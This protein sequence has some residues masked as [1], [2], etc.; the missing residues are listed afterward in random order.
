MQRH[1][2]ILQFWRCVE[3]SWTALLCLTGLMTVVLY[4]LSYV[5]IYTEGE[6][7]QGLF[8][9]LVWVVGG[10]TLVG[11][12]SRRLAF[13]AA[14][15]LGGS[16][17]IWQTAQIRKWAIMHE[18]VVGIIRY[19]EA[20]KT[21][22]GGYPD[23]LGGYQFQNEWVARHIGSFQSDATNGLRL[24]YFINDSGITYWYASKSG[25]GYYPD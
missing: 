7:V 19:A 13:G 2:I 22:T 18:E 16:L 10:L 12:F 20:V 3:I 4:L 1:A 15:L 5:V 17:L 25:F 21:Q 8:T 23:H 24:S 11:F 9:G 14:L 6:V